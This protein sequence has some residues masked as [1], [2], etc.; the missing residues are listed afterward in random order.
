MVEAGIGA[1]VGGGILAVDIGSGGKAVASKRE[2]G[3]GLALIFAL[4]AVDV[5]DRLGV[6][7]GGCTERLLNAYS[8][9]AHICNVGARRTGTG[10]DL[11]LSQSISLLQSSII[12]EAAPFS[13]RG[14][15]VE[16]LPTS[17]SKS[18]SVASWPSSQPVFCMPS[19]AV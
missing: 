12:D 14:V 9:L 6:R 19:E 13:T 7:T 18:T 1:S 11:G 8:D 3:T 16:L 2:A 15:L 10:S 17:V 4:G 5:R